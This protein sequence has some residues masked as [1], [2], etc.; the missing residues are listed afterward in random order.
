MRTYGQRTPGEMLE[1]MGAPKAKRRTG[2]TL[3]GTV[4]E[5]VFEALKLRPNIK[6]WN[7]PTGGYQLP[8]GGW[9][10]YGKKGSGDI[11]GL[12]RLP[13][14]I[15]AFLSIETKSKR[16]VEADHQRAFRDEVNAMGGCAIVA[17]SAVEALAGID[18]FLARHK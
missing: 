3:E 18:A 10:M 12:I 5:N 11:L 17:K 2:K 7:N 4:K 8:S 1:L 9:L 16:G 13:C 14:G 15:A 6:A